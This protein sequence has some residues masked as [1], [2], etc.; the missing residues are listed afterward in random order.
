MYFD[1]DGLHSAGYLSVADT[2]TV[3]AFGGICRAW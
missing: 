1:F 2:G 3:I